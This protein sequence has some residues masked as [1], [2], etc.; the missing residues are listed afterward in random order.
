MVLMRLESRT[1]TVIYT[2][3]PGASK[4][5]RIPYLMQF[6]STKFHAMTSSIDN[7]QGLRI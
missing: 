7:A 6:S 2:A 5:S 3:S 4:Q 1:Y